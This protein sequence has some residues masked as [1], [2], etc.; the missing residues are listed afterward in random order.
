MQSLMIGFEKRPIGGALSY[1]TFAIDC[2]IGN[3]ECIDRAV[4]IE[5]VLSRFVLIQHEMG[6]E[7]SI[8]INVDQKII[9]KPFNVLP[10]C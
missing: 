1:F 7:D 4:Q 3:I 8:T 5:R 2:Y 6:K 10:H 9:L